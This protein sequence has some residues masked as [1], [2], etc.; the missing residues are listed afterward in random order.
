MKVLIVDDEPISRKTMCIY[1][2]KFGYEALQAENGAQA[3]AIWNAQSPRIVLTDWNMPT[4]NGLELCQRI[5]SS[6]RD[7]Y[8][9]LIMVTSRDESKDLIS[10]F[11]AGVDD[12]VTKPV[13]KHELFVRL[14]A[15]E[16]IFALQ[17]KDTVIF[18]LAKLAETRD[19][20]TGGHLERIQ[21]YC[22]VLAEQL[23][24]TTE[25]PEI[26]RTFIE[27]LFATSPL[28]DVGKVG[29]PDHILL[30]PGRLDAEEFEVMKTHT[31]IGHATLHSAS[32]KKPRAEYLRMSA[33]IARSHHEKWDGSGYPDGLR[34][35]A[36]P[37][38][39]RIVAV[40]DVYD[41]LISKRVYKPAFSHEQAFSIIVEEGGSHFDP[42]IVDA[43]VKIQGT[44]KE[45]SL[46][47][48]ASAY[49]EH[50]AT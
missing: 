50:K 25:F 13:N 8:T 10:G 15:S 19:P 49:Q 14:K 3:F 38:S 12:Y 37:L 6:E 39:A 35:E 36:I 33:E 40:A 43:F 30:K 27:T 9:Y 11:E 45:I 47:F 24:L 18:A 29:I 44:V 1:L 21:M 46:S 32:L 22:R 23:S 7:D 34:G 31:T 42:R 26:N 4:M 5:R 28:H 17:D 2:E 48:Q 16:R 20:E 41:A